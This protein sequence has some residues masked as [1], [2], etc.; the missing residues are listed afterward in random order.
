MTQSFLTFFRIISFN[1][2]TQIKDSAL[3]TG[4]NAD[5]SN[6]WDALAQDELF[7]PANNTMGAA[8]RYDG[9]EIIH[10]VPGAESGAPSMYS[11]QSQT[12]KFQAKASSTNH[13]AKPA[14]NEQWM[15]LGSNMDGSEQS[16]TNLTRK[17]DNNEIIGNILMEAGQ[18]GLDLDTYK[19][20]LVINH[21]FAPNEFAQNFCVCD[22]MKSASGDYIVYTVIGTDADGDYQIQRRYKEFFLLRQALLNR[23]CGFYVPPIP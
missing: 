6:F 10:E 16:Q 21:P 2:I 18:E 17:V 15:D 14:R 3:I 7:K 13:T 4:N 1:N 11:G 8:D 20:Q 12:A 5:E 23:F 19:S 9:T 22:P